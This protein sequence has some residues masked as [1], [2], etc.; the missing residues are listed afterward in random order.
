M[1]ETPSTMLELGTPLP[2]FTLADSVSGRTVTDRD[3]AGPRG[4]LVMFL[5]NHCPFVKHVV[6][7]IGRLA[8]DYIAKGVGF[9]AVNS[10]DVE[11][12]PQDGPE[13]M[14]ALAIS[15]GWSFP[16]ALDA[17][18]SLG[19]TLRAACTPDY[20]LFDGERRLVYRGRLDE[21]RPGSATPLTGKELRAALDA[22]LA[23]RPADPDQRPSVGCSI[24]WRK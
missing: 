10:N 4:L 5:C 1:A 15:E 11:A 24:K 14:K 21:S 17:D 7:E 20:F 18:Q 9:L 22:T 8:S 3:A 19:Q 16:F 2:A 12:Y 13:H 23:G 6:P